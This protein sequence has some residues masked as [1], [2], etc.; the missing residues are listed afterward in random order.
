MRLPD[1]VDLEAVAH[2]GLLEAL[3]HDAVE[4]PD[5]RKVLHAGEAE[6]RQLGEELRHQH[7]RVGAVDA[8]EHRRVPDHRQDL[9]RHVLDDLVGV[10]VGE[11]AG[12]RAAPGHAIAAGIVDDDQVDAAGLLA[13]G[14]QAGAGA[15]ADDRHAALHH[16]AEPGEDV[17]A[18]NHGHGGAILPKNTSLFAAQHD[19]SAARPAFLSPS[20]QN[21]RRRPRFSKN[22]LLAIA[23]HL[24]RLYRIDMPV[25][26]QARSPVVAVEKGPRARMKRIMLDTA[27]GLMQRGLV[28]SVSDVAEAAAVSRATAYRY[29]PSQAA[30]I[31]ATV[32]EAL[33]PILEWTSN[34]DDP[35]ERV[36]DL[37]ELRLAAHRGIRGDAPRRAPPCP[38]PMDAP[39]GRHARR[40]GTLR[41]RPP[42]GVAR[43]R[44][45]TVEAPARPR[46]HLTE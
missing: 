19:L 33:G 29:F 43:R 6:R 24:R 9:A 10:A 42:Q 7:E 46:R 26:G 30:L 31:Q 21:R 11:Q 12:R 32:D 23:I 44:D 3:A 2:A 28:P 16:V 41:P 27:M 17:L 39:P 1:H 40:R 4:Q 35:E 37:L 45:A 13:L 38:R 5:R 25:S 34:S 15:A 8:G 20:H 14:R 36:T 22:R 18:R